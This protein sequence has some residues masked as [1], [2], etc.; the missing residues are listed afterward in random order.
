MPGPT[1]PITQRG[2]SGVDQPSATSRASRAPASASGWIRSSMPY[3]AQVGEV[4]AEGVGLDQVAADAEVRVVDR[5]DDVGA[6]VVEDLVAALVALEV[7]ER[8]VV[9]LQ[10]G[11]HGAVRDEDPLLQSLKQC[12][13]FW[14]L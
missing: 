2:R 12:G 11:A 3:S 10:H 9:G 4:G 13:G 8:E 6:G 7:V 5:A 14:A 1:E